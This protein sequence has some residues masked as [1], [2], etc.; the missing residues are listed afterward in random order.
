MLFSC[1]IH[2]YPFEN[3]SAV[4]SFRV[5]EDN[6][7]VVKDETLVQRSQ[8]RPELTITQWVQYSPDGVNEELLE[9]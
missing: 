7:P 5:E 2:F 8:C 6:I 1:L 4:L 9:Y 3:L